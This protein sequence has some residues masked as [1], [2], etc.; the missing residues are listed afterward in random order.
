MALTE[1][2]YGANT[3]GT[4]RTIQDFGL[5]DTKGIYQYTAKLRVKGLLV[6]VFFS[7]DSP[8][9]VKA[10]ETVQ[11]WTAETPTQKW[12]AIGV[13][14]GDRAELAQ[15][16]EA[17]GLTNVS[18]VLDFELYQTR[19]WGVSHLPSI[20]LISGKTGRV[21]QKIVGEDADALD[22]MKKMLADEV[23]KILAAE[24]AAK[25]AAEKA[26]EEKKAADAAKAAEAAKP[27]A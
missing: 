11:A 15:F 23:G 24:E 25:A 7:P 5:S 18:V 16:A 3:A 17:H 1:R 13:A 22:G 10:L 19:M 26:A 14:E 4:S 21:L 8:P 20:Y 27:A 12:T 9:S 6:V 2:F